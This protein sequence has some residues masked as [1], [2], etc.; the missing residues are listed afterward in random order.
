MY[1]SVVH[2]SIVGRAYLSGCCPAAEGG[3]LSCFQCATPNGYALHAWDS[4]TCE[5]A[6]ICGSP[7]VINFDEGLR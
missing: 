7:Q 4:E 3:H 6:E 5:A 1:A 2:S